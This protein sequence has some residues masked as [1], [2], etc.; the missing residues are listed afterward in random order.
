MGDLGAVSDQ[1]GGPKST[2]DA[3]PP[4]V[5]DYDLM[6]TIGQGGFGRVWLARNQATGHLRAVKVIPLQSPG[7]TDPAGREITSITRLETN[8]RRQHPNL[9]TIHHV[10]GGLGL[11]L[12]AESDISANSRWDKLE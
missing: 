5:S 12:P 10:D 7:T 1:N 4:V 6:R 2:D 8:V 9:L 3:S 11:S